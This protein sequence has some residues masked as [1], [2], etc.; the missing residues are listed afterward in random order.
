MGG[1]ASVLTDEQEW[2]WERMGDP[3]L[4]IE[5]RRAADLLLVCPASA[6]V[7]AKISLGIADSLF[8]SVV[9][10]WDFGKPAILCPAMN[11][12]MYE[13]KLTLTHEEALVSMGFSIIAPVSKQLACNDVGKGALASVEDIISAVK[14]SLNRIPSHSTDNFPTS[15]SSTF[16]R[17]RNNGF[18]HTSIIFFAVFVTGTLLGFIASWFLHR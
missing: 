15:M 8:L 1:V 5:L 11:T 14:T 10:A 9:R 4:H 13:H 2:S 3:V 12:V 18:K 16:I 6:D 7:M 17:K